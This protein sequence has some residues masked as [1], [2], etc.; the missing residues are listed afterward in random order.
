MA[1][2]SRVLGAG[3]WL[4]AA[5]VA[6]PVLSV[7]F[8]LTSPRGDVWR[9]LAD[10]I[11]WELL[12][13]TL[14]LL[15]GVGALAGFMGTVSAWLVATRRFPG[16]DVFEWA[17]VLPLAVPTYVIGFVF[18]ALFEFAGPV[19]TF[20]R[21]TL[22]LSWRFPNV[23]SYGGVVLAMSLVVYPYVYLLAL[24]AFRE[25]G[26]NLTEVARSLGCRSTAV[27][28]RVGLPLARPAIATGVAL[29]LMETLADFGTV[30]VFGY[31][32]LTTG[33]YRVWFGM[34]D[35]VAAGQL[36]VIL[37]LFALILVVLEQRARGRMR[38]VQAHGRNIARTLPPLTGIRGW[39]ATAFVSSILAAGFV[40]PTAVLVYWSLHAA[41]ASLLPRNFPELLGNT[42][43]LA[44][45]ACLLAVVAA[46]VLAY[47]IRSTRS[48][49]L[50]FAARVASLGYA[51][52]GSVIAVGVLLT[53][54]RAD[55]IINSALGW[56]ADFDAGLILTGS[57]FGLLFAY[58]VRFISVAFFSVESGLTRISGSMDESARSLG[59]GPGRVLGRVH[60]PLLRGSLLTALILVFVDVMK[61]M[62]ATMLIRPFGVDTLAVEVWQRTT[63]S[64][65]TEASAPALS[66]VAAGI[67]PVVVLTRLR[68]TNEARL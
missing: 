66:I 48:R 18:V 63:E 34:F 59:A 33:I 62:P 37:M 47:S 65:W 38:F 12:S 21:E 32:T 58:L 6:L 4:T 5:L 60:L 14:W 16:R 19:P 10:T 42:L 44:A 22:N 40:V 8:N 51:I 41:E 28:R 54:A 11:L 9:H 50:S 31:P 23:R 67:L 26:A 1:R 29:A 20:F 52:P 15:L 24:T 30:S 53:L 61:E 2:S 13:N 3:A 55:G 7:A 46:V 45:S 36:A 17:L 25:L 49:A 39:A 56:L 57:A 68:R 27:F 64:M 43:A 35:R